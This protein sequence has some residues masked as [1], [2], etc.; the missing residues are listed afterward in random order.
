MSAGIKITCPVCYHEYDVLAGLTIAEH[1]KVIAVAFSV[2]ELGRPILRY[3]GLFRPSRGCSLSTKRLL[4]LCTELGELLAEKEVTY[5]GKTMPSPPIV[6]QAAIE[7]LIGQVDSGIGPELP[8]GN[9]NYLKA[10]LIKCSHETMVAVHDATARKRERKPINGAVV[11][12]NL[13]A[14][15]LSD[16]EKAFHMR[17]LKALHA[18]LGG[19]NV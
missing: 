9:H 18:E 11:S 19:D 3:L 7:Q 12:E 17:A 1:K 14:P 4:E 16:E 15:E 8:L 13:D 6:W 5:K 10:I 2:H